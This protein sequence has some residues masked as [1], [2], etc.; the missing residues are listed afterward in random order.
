VR[1]FIHHIIHSSTLASSNRGTFDRG[2]IL[3]AGLATGRHLRDVAVTNGGDHVELLGCNRIECHWRKLFV[4][5]NT[6]K[7]SPTPC[8]HRAL[9]PQKFLHH[10][11]QQEQY[12]K[13]QRDQIKY[14]PIQSDTL[15][16]CTPWDLQFAFSTF[17]FQCYRHLSTAIACHADH[18][19]PSTLRRSTRTCSSY[20]IMQRTPVHERRSLRRTGGK[21]DPPQSGKTLSNKL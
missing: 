14:F 16:N 9:L 12:Q 20:A 13:H 18:F 17:T 4:S 21:V 5:S 11:L 3:Q 15:Y 6:S 19:Q 1:F 10:W 2:F 7:A 8:L